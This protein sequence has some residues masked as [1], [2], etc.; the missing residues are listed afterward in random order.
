MRGVVGTLFAV[1]PRQMMGQLFGAGADTRGERL[2][3][4]HF[5][6]RDLGLGA[7]LFRSLR[8]REHEAEWM[9]AGTAADLVDL[10]AIAATR[11]PRPLPKKAMVVGMAAIVLTDAA[12]TTLLL[13]ER[14]HPGRTER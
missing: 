5:A 14:R 4:A 6:V 3:A 8:R 9:L 13:R 2:V 10:C 12:L 1:R 7:G 11:K